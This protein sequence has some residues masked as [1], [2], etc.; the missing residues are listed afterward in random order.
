MSIYLDNLNSAIYSDY[1]VKL[2]LYNNLK[3]KIFKKG[4]DETKYYNEDTN[5]Y[6]V[7]YNNIELTIQKPIYKNVFNE[8]N[9]IKI[10]KKNLLIDYNNLRYKI[11][12]NLNNK[13]DFDKY[14]SIVLELKDYDERLKELIEYYISA[15][16]INRNDREKNN[17]DINKLKEEKNKLYND[18]L[19]EK[20]SLLNK[21]Y[22]NDYL[23]LINSYYEKQNYYEKIIDFYIEELPNI[24]EKNVKIEKPKINKKE[25][26]KKEKTDEEIEKEKLSKLKEKIKDKLNNTPQE[27]LDKLEENVKKEFFKLFKF[28]NQK[29][30][31][32]RS[33]KSDSFMKKPDIIKIISRSKDIEKR[34]PSNYQSFSKEKICEELYKL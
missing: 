19:E 21:K 8:M 18:I 28:K 24:E 33:Y 5:N 26:T 13:S 6:Y 32:S 34:L 14:N 12:H 16:K 1:L 17:N 23:E 25:K 4:S 15:N 29:E 11:I 9:N 27:K 7:K 10:K 30:C 3:K 22:I 20:D 31:S 2:D